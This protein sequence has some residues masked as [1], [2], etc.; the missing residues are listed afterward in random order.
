M[1]WLHLSLIVLLV[2]IVVVFAAQNRQ[3]VTLAFLGLSVNVPVAVLAAITY[4]FGMA[5]G[6]S[7][8]ALCRWLVEGARPRK[9]TS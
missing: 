8:F 6:G 2:A 4:L 7:L 9:I 3:L 1:R 5:T